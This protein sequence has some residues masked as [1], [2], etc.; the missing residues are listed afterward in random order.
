MKTYRGVDLKLH[1]F[2]NSEL[3]GGEWSASSFGTFTPWKK[4][5]VPIG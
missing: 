2:L 1:T 4:P 3:D 5:Q